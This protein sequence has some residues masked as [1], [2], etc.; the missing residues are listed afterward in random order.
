MHTPQNMCMAHAGHDGPFDGA[1]SCS[2]HKRF[3]SKGLSLMVC[4]RMQ[5]Q[6]YPVTN[7]DTECFANTLTHRSYGGLCDPHFS[8]QTLEYRMLSAD[9]PVSGMSVMVCAFSAAAEE[10][11]ERG[12][13]RSCCQEAER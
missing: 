2:V 1:D 8:L 6:C 3:A 11:P 4:C 9:T 12:V 5:S 13:Q 10:V 7:L